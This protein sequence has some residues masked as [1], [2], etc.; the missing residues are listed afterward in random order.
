M[1]ASNFSRRICAASEAPRRVRDLRASPTGDFLEAPS[2]P[3]SR[4]N[5]TS[6]SS[7]KSA[8]GRVVWPGVFRFGKD[9]PLRLRLRAVHFASF[10]RVTTCPLPTSHSQRLRRRGGHFGSQSLLEFCPA[11]NA[12]CSHTT[13]PAIRLHPVSQLD[14]LRSPKCA[15]HPLQLLLPRSL[16]RSVAGPCFLASLLPLKNLLRLSSGSR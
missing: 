15:A 1:Q 11:S 7:C 13:S 2:P 9:N 8:L 12:P 5:K 3:R 6:N 16:K 10:A 14:P 4:S